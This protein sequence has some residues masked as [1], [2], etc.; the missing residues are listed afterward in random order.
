MLYA[1][2]LKG[3]TTPIFKRKCFKR[4][5]K[6]CSHDRTV[7][8]IWANSMGRGQKKSNRNTF[9]KYRTLEQSNISQ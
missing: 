6:I 3:Q 7:V 8:A 5:T 4:E 9:Q 2:S 1:R